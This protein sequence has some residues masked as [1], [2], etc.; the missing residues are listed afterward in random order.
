[1]EK[2]RRVRSLVVGGGAGLVAA[3]LWGVTVWLAPPVPGNAALATTV[4][5]TAVAA[6]G[7]LRRGRSGVVAALTAGFVGAWAIVT[8]L[9]VMMPLVPDRWVPRIVT[10]AMTPADNLSQSRIET[11]DPYIALLFLGTL[12]GLALVVALL[13]RVHRRLATWL[14]PPVHPSPVPQVRR[15]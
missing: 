12:M 14:L 6:A 2:S 15:T 13:P 8:A 9:D 1:M 11:V 3:A 10:V 4:V 5:F 7:W